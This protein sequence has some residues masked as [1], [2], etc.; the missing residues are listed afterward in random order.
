MFGLEILNWGLFGF[1]LHV[2][3]FLFYYVR[4]VLFKENEVLSDGAEVLRI[5]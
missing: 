2:N 1:G 3:R 4:S 5:P